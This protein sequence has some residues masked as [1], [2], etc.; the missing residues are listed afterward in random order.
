MY[1]QIF[2]WGENLMNFIFDWHAWMI[3][4]IAPIGFVL[5]GGW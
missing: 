1:A 2:A 4:I 3:F 5:P